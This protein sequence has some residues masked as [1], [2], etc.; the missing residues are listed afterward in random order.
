MTRHV[1]VLLM[2]K[3]ELVI[4]K[5]LMTLAGFTCSAGRMTSRTLKALIL[6]LKP[7]M[8]GRFDENRV[9]L[10]T[11]TPRSGSTWLGNLL[12]SLPKSCVLFE[13]LQLQHVPEAKSAGFSWRTYVDPESKWPDGEAFFRR[14]F[15]GRVLNGW[16]SREMSLSEAWL[17]QTMIIKFVGANRM[18]PWI[19]KTFKV[20]SPVLLISHPCAVIASQLK[21]TAWQAISRPDEPTFIAKYPLFKEALSKTESVEEFLQLNGLSINFLTC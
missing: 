19:C 1:G 17:S 4:T 7:Y 21:S 18:L 6:K 11:S 13:P 10:L 8:A 16:T 20:R 9:L 2:Y 12:K 5:K 14:V 3:N 15:E